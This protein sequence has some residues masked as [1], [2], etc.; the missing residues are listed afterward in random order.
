MTD[1][2]VWVHYACTL[3]VFLIDPT[4]HPKPLP[5]KTNSLEKKEV[6]L[7]FEFSTDTK[8]QSTISLPRSM[9]QRIVGGKK[10][11]AFLSVLPKHI[12]SNGSL[13]YVWKHGSVYTALNNEGVTTGVT[14]VADISAFV[15]AIVMSFEGLFLFFQLKSKAFF[16]YLELDVTHSSTH[17]WKKEQ[18]ERR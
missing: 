7:F 3:D 18:L 8:S 5:Q 9:Q 4:P 15:V 1:A 2:C 10:A 11:M 14:V 13:H 17:T 16:I 6:L 12:S